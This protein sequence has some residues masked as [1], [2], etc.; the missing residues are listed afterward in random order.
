M[1]KLLVGMDFSK[2][3]LHAFEYALGIARDTNA[4]IRVVWV[5]N[6]TNR[7]LAFSKNVNEDRVEAKKNIEEL[8]E[9]YKN[10]PVI[11][12]MD[13]TLLKGKVGPEI[14]RHA[15]E[16][17]ADLVVTGSHG[18]TGFEEYWIGSKANRI[19]IYSNCP[20]LTV[21]YSYS[22]K[23]KIDTI[24]MPID[25][26]SETIQKLPFTTELAKVYDSKIYLLGIYSTVLKSMHKKVDK[27]VQQAQDYLETR[28]IFYE[29]E[30][31][32][33]DNIAR[34]ILNF[35]LEKN[36]GL[37]SIMTEQ[38]TT[39]NNMLLGKYA[40]QIVNNSNIPVLSVHASENFSLS[41]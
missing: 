35:S 30:C 33:S 29:K 31:I 1:N 38:E 17:G 5:D 14:S 24:L 34:D 13:Y 32:E 9:Q 26:T 36:F 21:H 8:F 18:V 10:H 41:S 20:T 4:K 16:Y 39:V 40:H 19:V 12:N 3:S 25:N 7:E 28:N 15:G 37:I 11:R 6:N 22:F 23:E 27:M 2:G